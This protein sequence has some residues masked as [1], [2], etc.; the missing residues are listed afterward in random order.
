MKF[1]YFNTPTAETIAARELEEAQR[2]LLKQ[3]SHH[4]YT[5][6]MVEYYQGKI[7]RLTK[8]LKVKS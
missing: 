3:Q 4:E 5:G 7:N 8:Y 2:E 6:K 1:P